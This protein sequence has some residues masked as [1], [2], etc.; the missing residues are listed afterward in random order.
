MHFF[1]STFNV[2]REKNGK[3]LIKKKKVRFTICTH[4]FP[5][6]HEMACNR[7][8]NI[9]GKACDNISEAVNKLTKA[10]CSIS[11]SRDYNFKF[12]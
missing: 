10:L 8:T 11:V 7:L 6:I 12:I 5:E 1:F 2:I 4:I 3:Y 9:D